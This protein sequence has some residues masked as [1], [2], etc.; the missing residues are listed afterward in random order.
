MPYSSI[1]ANPLAKQWPGIS[2][3]R[4]MRDAKAACD[5]PD[6]YLDQRE[7]G[8]CGVV[9]MLHA[10]ASR[11]KDDF[12]GLVDQTYRNPRFIPDGLKNDTKLREKHNALAIILSTHLLN[13]KIQFTTHKSYFRFFP[14]FLGWLRNRIS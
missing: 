13:Q 10:L 2:Y 7:L 14:C 4:V 11:S 5:H 9:S 3:E 1:S 6:S 8:I 12:L